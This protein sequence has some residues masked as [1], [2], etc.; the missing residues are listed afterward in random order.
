VPRS[1]L[2][3]T[4]L[5]LALLTAGRLAASPPRPPAAQ[6]VGAAKT[7]FA[8]DVYRQLAAASPGKNLFFAPGSI[9]G[10]LAMTAEGARGETAFQMGKVLRL[11]ES[12][13]NRGADTGLVPWRLEPV[14]AGLAALNRG[15]G[16]KGPG[17]E[18]S[19]ANAVWVDNRTRL[20]RPFL[21]TITRHYGGGVYGVDFRND[22]A[23]AFRQINAWAERMTRGRIK[24]VISPE[25]PR[26]RLVLANAIYFK[27]EWAEKFRTHET[28]HEDF[29]LSGRAKAR[30][31][32]MGQAS[33][34]SVRYAAFNGDGTLFVTPSHYP[35]GARE[36]QLYPD[37]RGLTVLEMPY[38]GDELSM[39]LIV[40]RSADGLPA[41]ERALTADQL[42]S[43]L[44]CL[45][46]RKAHVYVP[47]FRLE[48]S[49]DLRRPL[50]GLGMTRAFSEDG[51][52][53]EGM[54]VTDSREKLFVGRV[55]QKAFVEVNEQGTEAAAVTAVEMAVSLAAAPVALPFTPTF[56]ADRPFL[57]LI[58]DRRSGAVLFLGRVTDP[59]QKG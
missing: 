13:R 47:K 10:A 58:R 17:H 22:P 9:Y 35:D 8:L 34:E 7:A 40:P 25:G 39:V 56:K 30:V 49:Y 20:L 29:H 21:D 38:R 31:Q 48:T 54:A 27:G 41:L 23:G 5:A 11:P 52:E 4:A 28:T 53:F 32:T 44:G 36:E 57:F 55:V 15:L 26:T 18:V 16:A 24:N 51:A 12:L 45:V 2:Y 43:W 33:M 37:P 1:T 3:P 6:E 50:E 14:H 46:Q 19:V 59:R 42:A